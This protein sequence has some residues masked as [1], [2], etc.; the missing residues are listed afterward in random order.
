M[1]KKWETLQGDSEQYKGIISLGEIALVE[2]L[3]AIAEEL[4]ELKTSCLVIE[5]ELVTLR[6]FRNGG[7]N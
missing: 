1:A 3:R 6:V 4:E 7:V 2:A 5:S